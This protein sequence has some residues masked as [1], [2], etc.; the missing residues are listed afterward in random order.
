MELDLKT[1]PSSI[2][3]YEKKYRSHDNFI[4]PLKQY[5]PSI[6][7]SE[8]ISIPNKFIKSGKNPIFFVSSLG[9]NLNEGDLSLH[10]IETD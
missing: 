3:D 7:I 6:G 8:I 4:E 2:L 5:T 9:L 1:N 10:F